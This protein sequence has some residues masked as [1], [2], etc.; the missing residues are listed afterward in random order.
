M[1]SGSGYFSP[2]FQQA[3]IF[4]KKKEN[5]KTEK[6]IFDH[7]FRR[8]LQGQW[9]RVLSDFKFCQ[10]YL[11]DDFKNIFDGSG[12]ALKID[13]AWFRNALVISITNKQKKLFII[14]H[15]SCAYAL[16]ICPK[17]II[18]H[19]RSGESIAV[20]NREKRREVGKKILGRITY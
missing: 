13:P 15:C 4:V 18:S 7:F 6:K 2:D 9:D 16:Q 20:L 14:S 11:S 5:A 8:R 10:E 19:F 1:M 17:A 12:M 3:L